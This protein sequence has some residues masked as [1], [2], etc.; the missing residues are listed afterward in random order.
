MKKCLFIPFL[1]LTFILSGCWDRLEIEDIGFVMAVALDPLEDKE[2]KEAQEKNS[3]HSQM[4]TS[5]YQVAIPGLLGGG[6]GGGG[7]ADKPFFNIST[8]GMTSFKMRRNIDARRSRQ[9]IFEHLKLIIINQELARQGL[10]E[11]LSD[12]YTRNHEMRRKTQVYISDGDAKALLEDK[13]PLENMPAQSIDMISEN[14][15]KV[16]QMIKTIMIADVVEGVTGKRSFLIPRIVKHGKE[17]VKFSGAAIFLGTTNKM[18]GWLKETD[19]EGYNWIMGEAEKGVLEVEYEGEYPFIFETKSMSTSIDYQR[20]NDQDSFKIEIIAEGK[21]G[22][23]WLHKIEINDEET[24]KKLEE[25]I[26][27]KIIE[28]ANS[29]IKKMQEEFHA[30]IFGL[31]VQVKQKDYDYWEKV[32]MEWDGEKGA[33]SKADITVSAKVQLR[34][35]MLQ[36]RL[37]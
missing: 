22:E 6:D 37:D 2:Q 11:H 1:L 21:L 19:I 3:N 34:H 4:F 32:R 17:G 29:T 24:L 15:P 8:S 20:E 33:F 7:Q 18:I 28:Q 26:V 30:D 13:L 14:H 25:A 9:L 5:T 10:L 31:L 36:E 16:L 27:R 12:F 23:S 35:Y